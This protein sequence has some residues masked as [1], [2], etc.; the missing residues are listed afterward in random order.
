MKLNIGPTDRMLRVTAGVLMIG[1]GLFLSGT[2]GV[3]LILVGLVPLGTGLV[4]NCPLYR[5]CKINT[6]HT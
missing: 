3:A 2:A 6:H 4:G 5:I 1:A